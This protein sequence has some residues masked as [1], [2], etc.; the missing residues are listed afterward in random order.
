MNV[1]AKH[2]MFFSV[3]KLKNCDSLERVVRGIQEE[4]FCY[5]DSLCQARNNI[6]SLA[7][8]PNTRQRYRVKK[9]TCKLKN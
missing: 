8:Q 1:K 9:L 7:K 6:V 4:K 2:I 3:R 5:I